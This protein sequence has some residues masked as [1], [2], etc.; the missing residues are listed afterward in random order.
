[1]T[2]LL[3]PPDWSRWQALLAGPL[4]RWVPVRQRFETQVEGDV[5]AAV[6]RELSRPAVS[7]HLR[8]GLSVALGVGSRG[9]AQLPAVVTAAVAALREAGCAPFV[10]PAMG[11]HGGATAEG[12]A[13]LLASYGID[14]ARVGAPV[15]SSLEVIEIGRLGNGL[16]LFFDRLA[17]QADLVVPINRVKP[18]TSFRGPVESGLTKMLAIGFGKHAGATTLH[19]GGFDQLPQRLAEAYELIRARTPFRFGLT[20]IENAAHSVAHIEAVPAEQLAVREPQLLEQARALMARILIDQLDL[21]VVGQIGKDLSG[22]G[23]DPNVT[24]RSST[25]AVGNLRANKIVV[26]DLSPATG[27]NATG[28]GL[29][30]V[31]TERV[32]RQLDLDATWINGVTSTNLVSSRIPVFMPTD[33]A[34]I[35]LGLKTC[36]RPNPHEAHVAWVRSTL[37]LERIW[38]SEGLWAAVADQ[39]AFCAEGPASEVP[40]NAADRLLWE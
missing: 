13:A 29:A 28:L 2:P 36:G 3:R 37:D 1:M 24:G 14:E 35:Q 15:R 17:L 10:V 39:P 19:N 12:Q 27:G 7:S 38:L 34:A 11:S 25:G 4:P 8:P 22:T 5:A 6:R 40:F 30:D 26:L 32:V 20:T 23:M 9:L 31:T 33:R 16:P 18:H 21:L